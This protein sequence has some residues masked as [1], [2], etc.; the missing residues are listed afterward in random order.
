MTDARGDM[1]SNETWRDF[2]DVTRARASTHFAISIT[3]EMSKFD[4]VKK[5]VS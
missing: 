2:F 5:E 4:V 1:E 3:A